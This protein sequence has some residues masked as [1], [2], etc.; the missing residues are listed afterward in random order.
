[1]LQKIIWVIRKNSVGSKSSKWEDTA[2]L[3]RFVDKNNKRYQ[4]EVHIWAV[5]AYDDQH[6]QRKPK[7]IDEKREAKGGGSY[8]FRKYWI[9]SAKTL[10][11]VGNIREVGTL[12]KLLY[13][14]GCYMRNDDDIAVFIDNDEV[15]HMLTAGTPACFVKEYMGDVA[16]VYYMR[17]VDEGKQKTNDEMARD[18]DSEVIAYSHFALR[19]FA[20]QGIF[21][22]MLRDRSKSAWNIPSDLYNKNKA[23][24]SWLRAVQIPRSTFMYKLSG[25]TDHKPASVSMVQAF[26]IEGV[27]SFFDMSQSVYGKV[28]PLKTAMEE[29]MLKNL[30][31]NYEFWY[32][33]GPKLIKEVEA[34]RGVPFVI[35][36]SQYSNTTLSHCVCVVPINEKYGP[37]HALLL[38]MFLA[39]YGVPILIAT[40][41][42]VQYP[43]SFDA[44]KL[45]IMCCSSAAD[46]SKS[47]VAIRNNNWNASLVMYL[48]NNANSVTSNYDQ[49]VAA[50]V[51]CDAGSRSRFEFASL[52]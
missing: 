37:L 38:C 40:V 29:F 45:D 31:D 20:E 10:Q 2:L 23:S 41:G 16:D 51:A 13:R 22:S 19:G 35:T 30:A 47:I 43:L 11:A 21:V 32:R 46:R 25:F 48:F 34:L 5:H 4:T 52:T 8:M 6:Q 33:G 50:M 12:Q 44:R 42:N 39:D 28:I 1:M 26:P 24:T 15:V 18:V 3:D 17:T 49:L 7:Q 14:V 36:S 27:T 9:N